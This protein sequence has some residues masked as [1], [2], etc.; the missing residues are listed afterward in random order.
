MNIENLDSARFRCV[1]PVCGGVCCKNGRPAIEK[2]E[3]ARIS[4]NL[5]KFLPHLRPE[6]RRVVERKGYLTRRKKEGLA[7]LGVL[8]GWCLFHNE[9]CVLHKVGAEEGD[10]FRYKPWRCAV[11]PLAPNGDGSWYVRQWKHKGEAWDLFCLNPKESPDSARDTLGEE[12][13]HVRKLKG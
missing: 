2:A 8:G 11:F 7:T 3:E 9:G 6:A 1:F 10:K 4:A 13:E 12:V 5:G